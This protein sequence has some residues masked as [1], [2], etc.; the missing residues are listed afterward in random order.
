MS[1]LRQGMV[2]ELSCRCLLLVFGGVDRNRWRGCRTRFMNR[3]SMGNLA[4]NT[5]AAGR[6]SRQQ[7]QLLQHSCHIRMFQSFGQHPDCT[8]RACLTQI[9]LAFLRGVHQYGNSHCIRVGLEH[10]DRRKAIHAR[11][12]MIH[13]NHI[14]PCTLQI[15]QSQFGRF[16]GCHF[17]TK[18][19]QHPGQDMPGRT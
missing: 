1:Q 18:A 3:L 4:M 8:Q 12:K 11:H 9:H 17:Q 6:V 7:I 10:S 16:H 13:K 5:A 2:I 15:G 19:L 14:R